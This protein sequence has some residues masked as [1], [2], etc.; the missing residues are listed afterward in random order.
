MPTFQPSFFARSA[1]R[2]AVAVQRF[3][4]YL[5]IPSNPKGF[6]FMTTQHTFFSTALI[7]S[8]T[9]LLQARPPAGEDTTKTYL[10]KEVVV[11][12]SRA[13][14]EILDLPMAVGVVSLRDL[15]GTRKLGLNEA[16]SLVPGVLAQSR[17]GSQ[18]IRL[19]IRG[20]GARGSGDRS[21][22]GTVRGIK[23]LIDG[24]PE[25]EPDGRT[26]LD[27][28][29]LDATERIE[30]VRS[31]AST[32]FGNASGGVVNLRTGPSS[33]GTFVESKNQ[34][35][36]FNFRKN[37]ISLGSLLGS[38]QLFLSASNTN[39]DG[40]RKNSS[41][42]STQIHAV[43]ESRVNESTNLRMLTSAVYN[44]F[45]APGALTQA[46]F[47]ADPTQANSGYLARRERRENRTGRLAFDL[48]TT[49]SGSHSI[50]ALAYITPKIFAR[51]ERG[52]YRDFNR[53]HVGGGLVYAWTG[54]PSSL[55]RKIMVGADEAYQDG[56]S[57][58]YNLVNGDRGDSLRTNKREG[59]E[60]FGLFVQTE[61]ALSDDF[62][63]TLG[64]RF[65]KQK[66]IAE[67]FAAAV[68]RTNV[69]EE[70][71]F[72]HLTPKL[73]A[74]YKLSESHSLYASIGGGLEA[75]AFNEV[76]PPP[77]LPNIKLNVLL[78]PM[79]STTYEIG[80]KGYIDS[81]VLVS[82]SVA[83]YQIDIRNEIIPFNG[84]AYFFTAGRSQRRG[85][86]FSGRA[87]LPAGFSVTTAL[88]YM[89]ASYDSYTNDLGNFSGNA[90]P[91]IP[92]TVFNS[93]LGYTSGFGLSA[94][95]GFFLVGS[96]FAD[97]ANTYSV[98]GSAIMNVGASYEFT[99]GSFRG[100]LSGGVNNVGNVKYASSAFMNPDNTGAFLEPGMPGNAFGG[101]GLKWT[102]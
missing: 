83:M 60:T 42:K 102:P 96:Y 61:L 95:V 40:W 67:E 7:L 76:D 86:E 79:T 8:A 69:P 75:P 35:G 71:S 70:L 58:F 12:A 64:G 44:E 26:P 63:F 22:A 36:D 17:S 33:T 24:I 38:S 30:I 47:D 62:Y 97:D 57:L 68:N 77:T 53:Y 27:M 5:K 92:R 34:L 93:R 74:L 80:A 32:L 88:T 48:Y 39:F 46:Q 50:D 56:S 51:S 19:T 98:P 1:T 14:G 73:S 54:E 37:N 2:A 43:L 84:G 81:E 21:N 90:V 49:L 45:Y 100:S 91:G 85:L 13:S 66:Y 52:T 65:D 9:A 10:G 89:A 28:I 31:N 23:V 87:S 82:Y 3:V 11:R 78:A 15:V 16:L 4:L 101:F 55:F 6:F 25:T 41:S 59:A 94:N 18:D 72:D 20:F 99:F 29:D